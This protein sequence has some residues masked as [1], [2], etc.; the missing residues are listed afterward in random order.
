MSEALKTGLWWDLSVAQSPVG[1]ICR[2]IRLR[3]CHGDQGFCDFQRCPCRDRI[4][5]KMCLI[6]VFENCFGL[7]RF[8]APPVLTSQQRKLFYPIKNQISQ[9]EHFPFQNSNI[10]FSKVKHCDKKKSQKNEILGKGVKDSKHTQNKY[11][12]NC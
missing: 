1:G 12:P 5:S 7:W 6:A 9:Q 10:T 11:P 8:S 4:M 2:G 3:F